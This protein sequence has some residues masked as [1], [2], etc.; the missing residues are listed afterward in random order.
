[1]S[2][3]IYFSLP[4]YTE[5]SDEGT[6]TLRRKGFTSYDKRFSFE[7][8]EKFTTLCCV[9]L[10]LRILYLRVTLL[11]SLSFIG[12]LMMDLFPYLTTDVTSSLGNGVP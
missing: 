6:F 1:M 8:I 9:L 5:K 3:N 12:K 7:N 11:I 4:S 2:L 10:F